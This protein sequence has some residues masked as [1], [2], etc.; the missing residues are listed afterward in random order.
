MVDGLKCQIS[1][2]VNYHQHKQN[3]KRKSVVSEHLK[4]QLCTI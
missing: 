4:K 1:Y 3:K 2:L